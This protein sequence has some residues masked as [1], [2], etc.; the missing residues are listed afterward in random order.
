MKSSTP[1]A[2]SSAFTTPSAPQRPLRNKHDYLEYSSHLFAIS[3]AIVQEL[4]NVEKLP[5]VRAIQGIGKR[6]TEIVQQHTAV[7]DSMEEDEKNKKQ[8][9]SGAKLHSAVHSFS[10]TYRQGSSKL[11]AP[12]I[13]PFAAASR[14][15]CW[16]KATIVNY[17]VS[18]TGRVRAE[19]N[20]VRMR[21][22][23]A[24]EEEAQ[25]TLPDILCTYWM[26]K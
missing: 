6:K 3:A 4:G 9:F 16:V 18:V 23:E 25:E 20:K 11:P 14:A 5:T 19:L 1:F 26:E 17:L 22:S 8:R 2:Q 15:K 21:P 10:E 12:E 7:M 24:D 13:S